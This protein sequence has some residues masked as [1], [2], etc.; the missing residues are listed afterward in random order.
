M[1]PIN[2][3]LLAIYYVITSFN[4]EERNLGKSG[5][6]GVCAY[7]RDS[8]HGVQVTFAEPQVTE[9]IWIQIHLQGADKLIVG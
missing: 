5:N 3:A 1:L 2:A 7:I 8:I 4:P 9:H 6:R